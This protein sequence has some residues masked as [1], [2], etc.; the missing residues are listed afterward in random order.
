LSIRKLFFVVCLASLL[1]VSGYLVNNALVDKGLV[2]KCNI[3][4]HATGTPDS[5]GNYIIGTSFYQNGT[6]AWHTVAT[7]LSSNYSSMVNMSISSGQWTLICTVVSL[8]ASLASSVSDAFSKTAVYI[9]VTGIATN[10]VL[11]SAIGVLY[12][13]SWVLQW[14]W[15]GSPFLS[16]PPTPIWLPTTGANYN[17]S[18]LY[19]ANY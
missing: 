17:V 8:N 7:A 3:T 5:L 9:N 4:V 15:T 2:P 14:Y 10:A 11:S 19:S 1:V 6:G 16:S 12:G 18:V 13:G